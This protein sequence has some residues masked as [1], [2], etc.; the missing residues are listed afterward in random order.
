MLAE[1]LYPRDYPRV[2][3][4]VEV[5]FQTGQRLS[6]LQQ[7]RIDPPEFANRIRVFVL[8]PPRE[9][10]YKKI[11]I[12]AEAHFE[13]GLVDEVRRLRESGLSDDSNALGSHGYRRVCEYL[14]GERSHESAV[15][16]TRQDVRNYAKRQLSWFRGEKDV[17]WLDGFGNQEA[18]IRTLFRLV[19]ESRA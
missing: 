10:L 9:E 1:R 4:A 18:T 2:Q 5:Y 15:E 14:R 3:R 16:K 17:E 13:N 11:N 6:E 12:R 8:N 7:K 19:A